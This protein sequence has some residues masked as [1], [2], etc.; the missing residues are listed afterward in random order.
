MKVE[1]TPQVALNL[2]LNYKTSNNIYL[3]VDA[4]YFDKMYLS[5]NP[6]YRTE[7]AMSGYIDTKKVDA[8]FDGTIDNIIADAALDKVAAESIR[9]LTA[10]EKFK[11]AFIV[12]ASIGK[13][14]Y[15]GGKQLGFSLE[16]KNLTN[17]ITKTGGFEQMRLFS[18]DEYETT[19][20]TRYT[21]FDSKYFYLYGTNYYLNVYFRF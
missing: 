4:E 20:G 8:I 19:T 7:G 2:G 9:T 14:W 3:S 12:N 17:T 1:S 16:I 21:R 6:L 15:I 13:T 5:M 10:Q 18:N 11:P